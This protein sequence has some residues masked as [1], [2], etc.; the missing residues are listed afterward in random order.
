MVEAFQGYRLHV[1]MEDDEELDLDLTPLIT[2]RESF[3]LLKNF[4]YFR[5]VTLD[6]LGGLC[7]PRRLDCPVKNQR[8]MIHSVY[9]VVSFGLPT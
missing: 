4:T 2:A 7:W 8:K 6:P 3:W 1:V 9:S 5:K